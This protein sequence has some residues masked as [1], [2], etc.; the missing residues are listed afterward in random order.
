LINSEKSEWRLK[1]GIDGSMITVVGSDRWGW[2]PL[3]EIDALPHH[4]CF[5]GSDDFVWKEDQPKVGALLQKHRSK[6]DDP[7]G[8]F[9]V[10]GID[11]EGWKLKSV[12]DGTLIEVNREDREKW[13]PSGSISF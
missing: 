7:K 10:R 6:W 9:E 12:E 11:Q 13:S 5:H 4:G 8:E 3:S 1:S 2:M